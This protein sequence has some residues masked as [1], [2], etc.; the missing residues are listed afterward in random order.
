EDECGALREKIGLLQ[1]LE[2]KEGQRSVCMRYFT[3]YRVGET[4]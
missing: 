1:R 4:Y 3:D 2:F